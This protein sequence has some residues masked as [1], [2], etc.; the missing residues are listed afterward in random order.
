MDDYEQKNSPLTW[1]LSGLSVVL[2]AGGIYLWNGNKVLTRQNDQ[3]ERRADSLLSV[4]LQL[5]T[6]LGKLNE[7]LA[8]A[9]VDNTDLNKRVEDANRRLARNDAR[10][11]ELRQRNAG[12]VQTIQTL[13]RNLAS[14]TTERDSMGN[15]MGAM[16]D[17][18]GWLTDSS[19]AY[20]QRNQQLGRDVAQLNTT[21]LTMVPRSALTGDGFRVE[22]VKGN[23]KET[24][25]AKKVNTLL[26]SLTVPTELGLIGQQ[27]VYLSLTDEQRNPMMPALHSTTVNRPG[28]NEAIAVHAVQTVNFGQSPQ[29]IS[30]TINP[31]SPVKPGVYRAS[32]YTKN[33]YLGA[34]EFRLRDSFWFF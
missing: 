20:Q 4:R 27:E 22:T 11:G 5:E 33:A 18:I 24:A 17:K 3:A 10:L 28:L 6:D 25:K 26:V 14:L 29:R 9:S 31:V 8:T 2:L 32:V 12:R 15:Q 1:V 7:Q 21:L 30:F 13:N 23:L 16:Q 19:T 34:T